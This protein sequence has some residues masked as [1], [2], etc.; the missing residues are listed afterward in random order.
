MDTTVGQL[1]VAMVSRLE[2]IDV[3]HGTLGSVQGSLQQLFGGRIEEPKATVVWNDKVQ[4]GRS[5]R[6]YVA[7]QEQL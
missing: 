7:A 4:R 1:Y 2:P 3:V 6:T 5:C